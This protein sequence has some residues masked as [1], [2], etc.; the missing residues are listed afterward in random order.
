[1][2]LKDTIAEQAEN[3][4]LA[5]QVRVGSGSGA[6]AVGSASS[7]SA[8]VGRAAANTEWLAAAASP[9]DG[10]IA[11]PVAAGAVGVPAAARA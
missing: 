1:M 11:R 2:P 3:G 9:L 8:F 10:T 6:N 7:S 4:I 5:R